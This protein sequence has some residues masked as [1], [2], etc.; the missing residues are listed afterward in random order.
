MVAYGGLV[1]TRSRMARIPVHHRTDLNL[2]AKLTFYYSD[3]MC[4]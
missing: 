1:S 2:C 3:L 4:V